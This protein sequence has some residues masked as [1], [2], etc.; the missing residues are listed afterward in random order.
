MTE[1][2]FFNHIEDWIATDVSQWTHVTLL[3]YFCHKYEEKNGVRFRLV[4]AKKGPA[5]GKEAA[6]FAKLF[7]T[8]APE[9]YKE[10]SK[11]LKDKARHKTNL[12]IYNYINWMFDY[13]FRRGQ[14]SVN[15]TR[16][17]LVSSIIV[18]F[19]RMYNSY[20]SKQGSASKMDKLISWCKQEAHDIFQSHQLERED[21]IKMIQRYADMY[22][23]GDDSL[24]RRVLA[25]AS[26][27]GLL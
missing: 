17:F 8:L 18:E 16:I 20:L 6:D 27:V 2:E 26:E 13:K 15:G 4:R 10:L 1:E 23:L 12:K 25:K 19:E 7:R 22:S 5:L 24:E 14:Q 11:P 9:N 3:A 21:D